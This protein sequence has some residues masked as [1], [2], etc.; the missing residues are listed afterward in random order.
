M[1]K[2]Q[3]FCSNVA[4]LLNEQSAQNGPKNQKNSDTAVI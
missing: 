1:A 3:L 2:Q 4:D